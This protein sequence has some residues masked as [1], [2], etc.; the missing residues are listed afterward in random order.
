MALGAF[1][2]LNLLDHSNFAIGN[3]IDLCGGRNNCRS[4]IKYI[5]RTFLTYVL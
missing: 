1:D 4:A 3:T 5:Y 2:R